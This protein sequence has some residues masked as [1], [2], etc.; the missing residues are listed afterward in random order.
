[1]RGNRFISR[2]SL[3]RGGAVLG[4]A[5]ALGT[6]GVGFAGPLLNK[7][8]PALTHGVLSGDVTGD[9]AVIWTRADRGGQMWVEWSTRP[10]FADAR[11][12]PGPVFRS[13][14]DF[15][16]KTRLRDLPSGKTIHY[17]AWADDGATGEPV[18][19]S[20]RA[21]P[22]KGQDV[23]FVWSADIAGQ[24]WGINPDLGGFVLFDDMAATEPDFFL[25]SG[26]FYYGDN[27]LQ[28]SV[29]L[30]DGRVWKNV[31][32]DEKSKVA[33]TLDEFR[34]QYKYN[35]TDEPLRKLLA[36]APILSIWDDHEVVNNWYPGEILD[37]PNYT[38]KDV[39][40]LAARARKAFTEYMPN[41]AKPDGEGRIYRRISHGPLLDV[42]VL[43][44]R[45][46]KDANTPNNS[47]D[48]GTVLG[49]RQLAWLKRELKRSKATWKVIANS[50]PLSLIVGD[51]KEN[52]EGIAQR[53]NGK[54][55]GRES[56]IAELLSYI[57]A[58]KVTGTVWITAD[59]HYTAAHSYDPSRA[60]FTDFE[61]FWEF[62]AGPANAGA[63]GP[64]KLDTTFG[65]KVEFSKAPDKDHQNTTPLDGYQFFGE[66]AIDA[67]TKALTV[68]LVELGGTE[69]YRKEL[70]AA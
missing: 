31:V 62:V 61:P 51:G 17:R 19:G 15:T 23:K 32:S 12:V 50:L 13:G 11:K 28:E 16:A 30:P 55:L 70:P 10:D 35:L 33:Q 59:V 22:V 49:E 56:E 52:I 42:F 46:F 6:A 40:V 24:G 39:D 38:E 66:V 14:N 41:P 34:G 27:P 36:K 64:N 58:K 37:D 68:R 2:R 4:G 29:T 21:T 54:P 57:K 8:R 1:M 43:D 65:A 44:M 18:A 9:T 48:G 7:D 60:A 67:E 63:F 26:D 53:D 3:F 5:A 25:C 47:P 45:T 20:F 69:L